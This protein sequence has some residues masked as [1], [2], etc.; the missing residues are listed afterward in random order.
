MVGTALSDA[1]EFEGEEGSS[2]LCSRILLPVDS[3][4]LCHVRDVT[5]AS[6]LKIYYV[7]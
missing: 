1:L 3:Q 6:I 4:T 5:D 7:D 2:R